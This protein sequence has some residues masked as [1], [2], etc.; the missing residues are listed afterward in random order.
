[1]FGETI[2]D[3]MFWLS[4]S[5]MFCIFISLVCVL[6]EKMIFFLKLIKNKQNKNSKKQN[7]SQLPE[8]N[9]KIVWLHI[10]FFPAANTD[11]TI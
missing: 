6:C 7:W 10:M 9:V 2:A 1:M 3:R 8:F 11:L 4:S 5:V